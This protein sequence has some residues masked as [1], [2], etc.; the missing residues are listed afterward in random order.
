MRFTCSGLTC[1]LIKRRSIVAWL[2]FQDEQPPPLHHLLLPTEP[3]MTAPNNYW[4]NFFHVCHH[5]AHWLPR[6]EGPIAYF[7]LCHPPYSLSRGY[8]RGRGKVKVFN[9]RPIYKSA[10]GKNLKVKSSLNDMRRAYAFPRDAQST[11]WNGRIVQHKKMFCLA[12]LQSGKRRNP[13]PFPTIARLPYVCHPAHSK[14]SGEL[15]FFFF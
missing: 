13:P 14:P 4:K 9:E 11:I 2:K 7:I 12:T 1:C 8:G 3:F 6:T 5:L 10:R 15:F